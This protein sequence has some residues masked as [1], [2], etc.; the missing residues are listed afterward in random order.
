MGL[1]L[2]VHSHEYP[3]LQRWDKAELDLQVSLMLAKS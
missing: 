3:K 1:G 2:G